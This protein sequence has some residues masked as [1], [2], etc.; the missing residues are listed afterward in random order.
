MTPASNEPPAAGAASADTRNGHPVLDF[1][2]AANESAVFSSAMAA[3]YAHGGLAVELHFA[4][5][6]ATGGEVDWLVAFERI[7]DRRQDLDEDGFAAAKSADGCPVPE[8]CGNVAVARLEFADGAEIDYLGP[9]DGFRIKITRDAQNDTAA[10]DAELR[11]V[12][13]RE[14]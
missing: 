9:G 13:L 4:M 1:D 5:T 2:D 11:L 7:G 14:R 8:R 6:T 10:G 3:D 12:V